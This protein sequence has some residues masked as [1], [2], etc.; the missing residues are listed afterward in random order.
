MTRHLFAFFP[1]LEGQQIC[2]EAATVA[3]AVAALEAMAPG[4][5]HY[6]IDETGRLRPHVNAFIGNAMIRDRRRLTDPLA[7]G[8]KLSILQSLSGG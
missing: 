6:L 3:E 1:A 4:I 8:D 5:A 7:P 2:V